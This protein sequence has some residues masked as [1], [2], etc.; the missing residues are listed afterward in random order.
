MTALPEPASESDLPHSVT[1][2]RPLV[3]QAP[4]DEV[5]DSLRSGWIGTGIHYRALH[6]HSHYR[7]RYELA[8]GDFPVATD[9]SG[10]LLSLPLDATVSDSDQALV[11]STL[12]A[13]LND[14]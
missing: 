10:R 13:I 2:G 9:A 6:L 3:E 5:V 12:K 14:G 7:G 8:P 1:F 4:I 11:I